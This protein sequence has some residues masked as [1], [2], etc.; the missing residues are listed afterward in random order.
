[1][2]LLFLKLL[3]SYARGFK[4]SFYLSKEEKKMELT[5][6]EKIKVSRLSGSI[7]TRLC[8]GGAL[9]FKGISLA[10]HGTASGLRKVADGFDYVGNKADNEAASLENKAQEYDIRDIPDDVLAAALSR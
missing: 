3:D 7:M 9:A 5:D 6:Q 2:L 4:K 1:M 8:Q 10:T